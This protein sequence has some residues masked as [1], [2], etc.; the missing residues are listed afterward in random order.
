LGR[1]AVAFQHFLTG[2]GRSWESEEGER[3]REEEVVVVVEE[4]EE[5]LFKAKAM[6][7]EGRCL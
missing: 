6:K 2:K 1:C 4:E 5:G 7:E 3:E